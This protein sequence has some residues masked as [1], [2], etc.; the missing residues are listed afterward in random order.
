M[1][2]FLGITPPGA[3]LAEVAPNHS[4]RFMVDEAALP[5]GVKALVSLATDYLA[6]G[7]RTP[8]R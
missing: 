7:A 8:A 3:N 5:V 6:G 2:L 4:P 1:F